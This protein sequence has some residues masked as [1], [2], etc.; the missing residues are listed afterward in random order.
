MEL[1]IQNGTI[2]AAEKSFASDVRVSDGKIVEIG[3]N[4]SA[5]GAQIYDARGCKLFAGFIDAHTHL[6]MDNGVTMTADNFHTGTRAAIAG[7]TTMLLD[8]AT[9]NKG[10]TL[11]QALANWNSKAD[12]RSSCDY[13]FHMAITD[14]N[15]AVSRELDELVR[16][17]VTSFK[18]YL[19]Y[20]NLRVSDGQL[21]EILKRVGE[22]HGII[23]VH[24]ENGDL[25]NELVAANRRAGNLTPHFHPLSRP[26]YVEAEAIARYC[27][28]A[29]AADVPINIV[30]LSTQR[31][32]EEARRARLRGQK[33][34]IESCPHYF[35]L[36]GSVYDS[37]NFDESAGFVC[38]PP[39]RKKA[40]QDALWD[41]LARGELDTISTDHCSF[42]LKGQKDLGRADF[43]KIPNG[44]P[45][46]EHRPS[47]MYTFGVT[48]GRMTEN[49]MAALLSE[50]TARLFGMYPRKGVLAVGS[51]A[52]I[53]VWDPAYRG[54]ITA[55]A[56]EQNVDYTPYEGMKTVGRC[57]AVF[58]NGVQTVADGRVI[59]EHCGAYVARGAS[60]YY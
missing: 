48:A 8:F 10:E 51:D 55:K 44:L 15:E 28:I 3:Q 22:L 47:L 46:I 31:G 1:L 37:L 24:C 21:Y 58:L 59:R 25:V 17:G 27:Y 33:V 16:A 50:N 30:H 36:D 57:K 53:V 13:G 5:N 2:V 34:Y 35:T 14:W 43:G 41:A 52:D 56:Q 18:L 23:G 45:G 54:T 39:L 19:A 11:K 26:D 20:D 49:R 12:G 60:E 9:Q 4:L 38:S 40:D 29:E 32:L 7:G 42:N 6:D